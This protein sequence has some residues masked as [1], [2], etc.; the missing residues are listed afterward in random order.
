[1]A[2]KFTA[3]AKQALGGSPIM[4]GRTKLSTEEV[5]AKYPEGV[6]INGFDVIRKSDGTSYPVF[7]IKED[8]S[9]FFNGGS[10]AQK[11][12]DEW[13]KE[14]YGDIEG[15]NAELHQTGAKFILGKGKTKSNKT[16]TTYTPVE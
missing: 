1:M 10:L 11:I 14:G 13:L 9:V 2:N 16:I 4:N 5:I 3:Q 8:D 12:V 7:S 6:T 15:I